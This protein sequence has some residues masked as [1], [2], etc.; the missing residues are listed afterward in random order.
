MFKT[1]NKLFCL[2]TAKLKKNY[3]KY[4]QDNNV[5]KMKQTEM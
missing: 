4:C 5:M 3:L 2:L 1:Y